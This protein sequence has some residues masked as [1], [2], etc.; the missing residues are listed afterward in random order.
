MLIQQHLSLTALGLFVLVSLLTIC[1]AL[2]LDTAVESESQPGPRNRGTWE[3]F[4][5]RALGNKAAQN[6]SAT[7]FRYFPVHLWSLGVTRPRSF[8]TYHV[9]D[10]Y[11]HYCCI[12]VKK[13]TLAIRNHKTKNDEKWKE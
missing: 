11:G 6:L 3:K 5:L 4:D 9:H 12:S 1:L 13:Y 10:E 7:V 8:N 2:G